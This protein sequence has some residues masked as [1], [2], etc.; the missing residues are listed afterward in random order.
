[1]TVAIHSLRK[2]GF[3]KAAQVEKS[4]RSSP[5]RVEDQWILF[6]GELVLTFFF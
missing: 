2:T 5:M 4:L 6:A 3:P 1:M